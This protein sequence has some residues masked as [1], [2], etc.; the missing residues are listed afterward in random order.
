MRVTIDVRG[1]WEVISNKLSLAH[2]TKNPLA[3]LP[4]RSHLGRSWVELGL[5]L[6]YS[7]VGSLVVKFP[8]LD[9]KVLLCITLESKLREFS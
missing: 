5:T 2:A 4:Q 9:Q 8:I 7:Q 1:I 3:D 6:F